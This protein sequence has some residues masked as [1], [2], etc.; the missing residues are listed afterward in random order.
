MEMEGTPLR[1]HRKAPAK[2]LIGP[3]NGGFPCSINDPRV[4]STDDDLLSLIYGCWG[5][6]IE[7]YP[8]PGNEEAP[9][10][11]TIFH[12]ALVG[13]QAILWFPFLYQIKTIFDFLLWLEDYCSV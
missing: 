12:A 1:V 3:G 8:I 13:E 11:V 7:M 5:L 9:G 2:V 6:C 10:K 4:L